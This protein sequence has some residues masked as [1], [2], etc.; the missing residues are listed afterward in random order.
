MK[1]KQ[2]EDIFRNAAIPEA[3]LQ[4]AVPAMLAMLM[5]L[6]YNL[7]DTFFIGQTHDA[8]QV[9]AVSLATPVFLIFMSVGSVFGIGG[10]S[11]ISRAIG[12]GR[13]D[14][15]KKV[16]AFCM[17]GCVAAGL[18]LSA[19]FLIF[20]DQILTWI[21][22]SADT[23]QYAKTYLMIVSLCGPFATVANCYSNVI[24]AE[25]QSG[26]AM[27]G[28]VLGNLF[29]I[30]LDPVFILL[31]GWN[32][33]GAAVA[34]VIGNVVAACYYIHYFLRGNSSLSIR[35]KDVT[36][37][38]KVLWNVFAIGIPAS[39]GSLL[40]SLSQIVMNSLMT[41]YG[42]MALA[43]IGVAMKVTMITGM[44]CIGFGQGVQP[45][46]GYCVGAKLWKRFK[47]VMTFSLLFSLGLSVGMTELCYGLATQI[48]QAFL[49]EPEAFQYAVRFVYILLTTSF[50]FGVFYVFGNALQAMGAAKEAL[51]INL[52][53][54]GLIYIPA[55]FLM[56]AAIGMN[57]LIWAQPVAD[58]LSTVMVAILYVR[59]V[60]NM[61]KRTEQA[62]AK[63]TIGYCQV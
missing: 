63:N 13:Q 34:T 59:T 55:L 15:A 47:K 3:V 7:A 58:L 6:I 43:A 62:A 26:K 18:L 2:V 14:Y 8:L 32:I 51:L 19:C 24:R 60:R 25:G 42:D 57:G 5:V 1:Q 36:C 46:L 37:K 22:A 21:G 41:D 53:R 40:M 28:Q 9:A 52:S 49:T 29:N 30:V 50:L 11:V 39:L 33:A 4:N 61:Q 12:E 16:C 20:M 10:T 35:L 44:I 45:L 56:N 31:L 23:W 38:E 17:W 48:V 54:Q 27:M